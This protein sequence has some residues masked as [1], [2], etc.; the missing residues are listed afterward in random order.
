MACLHPTL[1]AAYPEQPEPVKITVRKY[2]VASPGYWIRS[3]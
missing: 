3:R 2:Q 1:A